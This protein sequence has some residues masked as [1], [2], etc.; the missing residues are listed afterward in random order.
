MDRQR[1]VEVLTGFGPFLNFADEVH[2]GGD[3]SEDG[4]ALAVGVAVAAEVEFGLW[5]DADGEL[6]V[7]RAGGVAGDGEAAVE[8]GEAGLGGGFVGD[9]GGGEVAGFAVDAG[10][11][12]FDFDRIDGLVFGVD[13]AVEGGAIGVVDPGVDIAEESGGRDW[14]L[15]LEDFCGDVAEWSGDD[16]FRIRCEGRGGAGGEQ[17]AGEGGKDFIQ[18]L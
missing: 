7:A 2:A 1:A 6:G 3:P 14:C 8:V 18:V 10:L 9:E 16:D 12:D 17:A 4:E 11:D 5:A 13:D 15:A